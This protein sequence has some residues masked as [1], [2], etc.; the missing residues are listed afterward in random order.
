MEPLKTYQQFKDD[1]GKRESSNNYACKNQWGFLGRYQ[2][3]KQRLCDLG[4]TELALEQKKVAFHWT[5]PFSEEIFLSNHKLQDAV[6]DAH[7]MALKKTI[8]FAYK[9]YL[10]TTIQGILVT[11][12]GIIACGHLLGLG[13]FMKFAKGD[14]PKDALGTSAQEYVKKFSGYEIPEKI[15]IPK[16]E[17]LL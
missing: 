2:F 3:G 7:V 14:T 6:F 16:F 13:G 5:A 17:T 15:E 4:L 9:K 8:N 10:D 11:L 1:L 12:S